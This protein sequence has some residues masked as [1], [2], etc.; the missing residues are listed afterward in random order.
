MQYAEAIERLYAL[1][2]ELHTAAGGARRKFELDQM[3]ALMAELGDPQRSFSSILIAGTNGKGSTAATLASILAAAGYKT[4]LYTSPHLERVNERI[5]ILDGEVPDGEVPDSDVQNGEVLGN[6]VLRTGAPSNLPRQND[7]STRREIP[8][9]RFAAL[10]SRVTDAGSKLLMQQKLPA[11]PSF[12]ETV[13][14]IAFCY[15]AEQGIRAAVLEVGLGGRLD[16]TNIVDPLLSVITDVSLDHTEW[17]GSTI[18]AIA[19]EKAG[20]LRQ[21]GVLITLPQHPEANEVIG[22]IATALDVRAINAAAY[23]PFDTPQAEGNA[24]NNYAVILE[25]QKLWIHSP[26]SGEHQRRNL[27]LAIASAIELRNRHGYI[28]SPR[29]IQHGIRETY[30]PGRLETIQQEVGP[31]YLLDVGH[32]PAGAWALRA[33]LSAR[34]AKASTLIFGCL[35]DKPVEELAQILFPIFEMVVLVEVDSPRTA[36]LDR[37][38]AAATA[39]GTQALLASSFSDALNLARAITHRDD[40]IVVTGSVFLVGAIRS[41]LMQESQVHA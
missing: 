12:F 15:F 33:A 29:A 41:L 3:R 8:D 14:A 31:N 40:E 34:P 24:G 10:F 25:G 4:G 27:A 19:R 6:D 30:W 32:N 20:I 1:G 2:A 13:T 28:I 18:G 16:A 9:Q 23:L 26:L 17:L 22:E 21:D 39:T 5:L 7:T 11:L 38:R 36:T 37:M 35:Q